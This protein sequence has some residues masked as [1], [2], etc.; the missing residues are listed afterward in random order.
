MT[1]A[2]IFNFV[3]VS[4]N[5]CNIMESMESEVCRHSAAV[6]QTFN[7]E[8]SNALCEKPI[9]LVELLFELRNVVKRPGKRTACKKM[10]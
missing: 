10:R 6:A 3:R 7:K 1:T 2:V 4:E 9:I 5:M 8:V